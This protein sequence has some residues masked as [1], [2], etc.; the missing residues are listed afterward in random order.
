MKILRNTVIIFLTSLVFLSCGMQQKHDVSIV[1][2]NWAEGIA[3]TYLTELV[4]EQ[5]GYSVELTRLEPGPIYAALSSGDADV[6]MDAWLPH[7][8][9]HYWERFGDKMDV[10]GVVFDNGI[11]GLVVPTYVDINSIEELNEN[12]DKF[13]GGKIYG[14]A[15]GAGIH[16]NT[17]K[18]IEEYSLEYEQISSSETSMIT[19]TRRAMGNEEWIVITGW[20]PHYM[21]NMF[22]LKSL[23]DP[24]GVYP[25]D[26][27]QIVSRKGFATDQPEIAEYFA[28]FKLDD[29]MIGELIDDAS[30]DRDPRVGA[31]IF[32]EKHKELL[33]SWIVEKPQQ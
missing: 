6:Y 19:A 9:E 3:M 33:D 29:D 1:Y 22:D 28:N 7:T 5:K 18:A 23:D 12:K 25:V 27:I 10:L 2:P 20:K 24:K 15:A 11:T 14:I 16:G 32:Y 21:W 17:E 8:H 26:E 13:E 30:A 31:K 4:L